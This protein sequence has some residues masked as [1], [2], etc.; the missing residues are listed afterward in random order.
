MDDDGSTG[1]VYGQSSDAGFCGITVF[2]A[3]K[4]VLQANLAQLYCNENYYIL[5]VRHY[6]FPEV[7]WQASDIYF[8]V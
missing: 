6:S 3:L 5:E 2:L 4:K 1:R 8:H 7:C